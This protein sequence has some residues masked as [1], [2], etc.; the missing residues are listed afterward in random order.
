LE[1]GMPRYI[2]T[3]TA[4]AGK[5][6]VLRLLEV[7][8]LSVVE[9]AATDVIA[10]NQAMGQDRPWMEPAFIDQIVALQR[11]R[12]ENTPAPETET[13][14]FDRSPV[15][16]LAL[17]RYSGFAPSRLLAR[18]IDRIQRASVYEPTV[19]FVRHQGFIERTAARRITFEDALEFERIHEQ[20]YREL[21]FS[22]VDVPA[23]PLDDR[24]ALIQQTLGLTV[25]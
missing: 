4:G 23:G 10:L 3:G 6:A 15:C 25:H 9:E 7:N 13:V 20:T 18:E 5:T 1:F 2:L 22:L 11:L 17:S 14:F 24:V 21:G 8:G 19:F 12:Q 16:T